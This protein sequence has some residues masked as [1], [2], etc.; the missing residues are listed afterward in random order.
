MDDR[1]DEKG[2]RAPAPRLGRPTSSFTLRIWF[3]QKGENWYA[4][5]GTLGVLGGAHIGAFDS[6]A[7]LKALLERVLVQSAS[8]YK[9]QLRSNGHVG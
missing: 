4:L 1:R 9:Q 8:Q 7:A 2:K 3:E 6:V 5:R